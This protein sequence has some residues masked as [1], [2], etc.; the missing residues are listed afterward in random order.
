MRESWQLYLLVLLPLVWVVTFAYVPMYMGIQTAF[1]NYSP[2]LGIEGSPWVGFQHFEAFIHSYQF[3]Q[4]MR[5]TLTLN[6]VELFVTFPAPI[7]LALALNAVRL[8]IYAR[9]VQVVTYAPNF[10]SMVLVVG[11]MT[12]MLNPTIGVIPKILEAT[13]GSSPNFFG[14][15]AWFIPL[16]VGSSVWQSTGFGAIIYLAALSGINPE[17][18]EAARVDGA[19]R[20]RRIWHIDLPGIR[21]IMV[22]MLILGVGSIMNTSF[23]K[24]LL[25]Q[26]PVN[27][28]VSQV[29]DTY[30]YQIA[31]QAPLPQFSYAA[32]IGLFKAVIA[33]VMVLLANAFARKYSNSGL[34]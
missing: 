27:M 26:N 20:L 5:N 18:H 2:A 6:L 3:P 25:L 14:S 8:K 11:M 9:I 33:L 29:I 16:F 34:F 13:L 17:L 22:I 30:V 7:I 21:P 12:L 32:A 19:S 15:T 31:L 1:R 24:V 10:I 4:L 23:E 28:D